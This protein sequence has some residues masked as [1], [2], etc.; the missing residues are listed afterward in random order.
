MLGNHHDMDQNIPFFACNIFLSLLKTTKSAYKQKF[1]VFVAVPFNERR[2]FESNL[3]LL[4]FKQI[5]RAS[6]IKSVDGVL[7]VLVS[8]AFLTALIPLP[9][10]ILGNMFTISKEAKKVFSGIVYEFNSS[11]ISSKW[12][13]SPILISISFGSRA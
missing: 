9:L 6:I 1:D 12:L 3:E 11:M 13:V 7:F 2:L 5:S 4:H 10:S 8:K